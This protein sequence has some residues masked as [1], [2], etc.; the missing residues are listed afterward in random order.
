[1]SFK[2]LVLV[3][4]A[5]AMCSLCY[6]AEKYQEQSLASHNQLRA[7]HSSQNMKLD[8]ELNRLAVACAKDYAQRNTI[9]HKCAKQLK[10][11]ENLYWQS[12]GAQVLTDATNKAVQGWYGENQY[13]DYNNPGTPKKQG[14]AT[15]HF[16]QLVWNGSTKL[17]C[18]AAT[19]QERTVV[20]CLYDPQGNMQWGG[21][22][23][24]YKF[25]K[26]NVKAPK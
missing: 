21:S 6:A 2:I 19:V 22:G 12:G 23:D 26:E 18:G 3:F 10:K 16:T 20:C 1:M 11:G 14:E 15:G 9:D 13:Y 4:V 5:S 25:Y 8:D 24:K 7:K 17:G